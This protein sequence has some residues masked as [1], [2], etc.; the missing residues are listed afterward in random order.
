MFRSLK[1]GTAFG[2]GVYV[3][4]SF[5]LILGLAAYLG[6]R[7]MGLFSVIL[8]I[9]LFGCIILHEFGH[10][11]MARR[12]GIQTR[13]ITIFPIGGVARLERMSERPWEEFLIAVAGPAVNI[14]IALGLALL[15]MLG[16]FLVDHNLTGFADLVVNL[17][18]GREPDRLESLQFVPVLL[19]VLMLSNIGLVVFNMIPAFPMDGGRVLRALLS[20]IVGHLPATEFAAALGMVVALGFA[21]TG[22]GLVSFLGLHQN[23][24][25]V[26]VGMFVLLAGQQELAAV[27]QR[28]A[29][30]NAPPIDALPTSGL[31][32]VATTPPEPGFSGF[33]FDRPLNAWIEWRDGRPVHVCRIVHPGNMFHPH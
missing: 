17:V 3:H 14:V 23:P 19:T 20:S 32:Q 16:F 11:L 12:Y 33:T 22:L 4:W 29:R 5:A 9:L 31:V 30:R 28:E 25:L 10:A 27:R 26:L 6:G 21:M 2:I 18:S 1:L 8:V 7:E 24:M 13:D 15:L